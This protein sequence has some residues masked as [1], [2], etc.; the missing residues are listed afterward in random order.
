MRAVLW[1]GLRYASR[2][3]S[4]SELRDM[5]FDGGLERWLSASS[6][7]QVIV[8]RAHFALTY[9]AGVLALDR[10][11]RHEAE[12]L[13]EIPEHDGCGCVEAPAG[14]GK[15][16]VVV[17]VLGSRGGFFWGQGWAGALLHVLHSELP[18]HSMFLGAGRRALWQWVML[19][20]WR[21]AHWMAWLVLGPVAGLVAGWEAGRTYLWRVCWLLFMAMIGFACC[22]VRL[23]PNVAPITPSRYYLPW[24]ALL[25]AGHAYDV[26][27]FCLL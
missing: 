11:T 27:A 9:A 19:V 2:L 6:H 8:D 5:A 23:L 18:G 26:A 16:F 15:T 21:M 10:L 24:L 25:A 14:A 3:W 4:V 7:H 13:N 20:G 22:C 12:K 1:Y 17:L